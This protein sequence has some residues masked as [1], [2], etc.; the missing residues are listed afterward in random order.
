MSSN[1]RQRY[2]VALTGFQSEER[3]KLI[4]LIKRIGGTYACDQVS[5]GKCYETI[6]LPYFSFTGK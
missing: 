5:F 6:V 4:V 1:L 3:E 2:L